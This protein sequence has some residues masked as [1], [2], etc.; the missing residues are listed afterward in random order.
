MPE[1]L[2]I[3]DYNARPTGKSFI[4]NTGYVLDKG[5]YTGAVTVCIFNKDGQMLIQQRSDEKKG[6][7]GLWDISV[8]GAMTAGEEPQIA[9]MR[10]TKEELGLT[11]HLEETRPDLIT[12]Y[13]N[14]FTFTFIVRMDVDLKELALQEE[15]VQ[16]VDLADLA[17]VLQLIEEGKFVQYRKSWVEYLFDCA[18][19]PYVF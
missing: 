5:E 14:G 19:K 11:I 16:A 2:D 15:E 6:W 12:T 10:E 4:R 17:K 13:S 7:P 9:A 1:Y 3:F 8:G 18:K